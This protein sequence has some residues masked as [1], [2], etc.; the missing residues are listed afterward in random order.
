MS[1]P[2]PILP[3]AN[4]QSAPPPREYSD[5]NALG[6]TADCPRYCL[7]CCYDLRGLVVDAI[8]PECGRIFSFE[9][10]ASVSSRRSGWL[11]RWMAR[12]PGFFTL[13]AICAWI[14]TA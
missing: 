12:P 13:A 10:L 9:S 4:L 3:P 1:A 8:C 11:V 2:L 7:T 5:T 14:G 6:V